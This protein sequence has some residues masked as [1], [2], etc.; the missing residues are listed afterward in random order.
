MKTK[1]S[2]P[3]VTFAN[4]VR[5]LFEHDNEVSIL[6]DQDEM[7]ISLYVAAPE[8]AEAL[9]ALLKP[10]QTFGNV[11]VKVTVIPGNGIGMKYPELVKTAFAGNKAL[12]WFEEVDSPFGHFAYCVWDARPAQFYDD[13]LASPWGY[14]TMLLEDIARDVLKDD[15]G[16]FHCTEEI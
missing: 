9:T 6:F 4:E 2:P 12:Y 15:L 8:K 5:A 10:Q 3:W 11:T 16:L 14:K 7:E 1:L 13:N